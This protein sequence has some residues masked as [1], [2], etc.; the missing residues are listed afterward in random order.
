LSDAPASSD[1][2]SSDVP[3]SS[4]IEDVSSSIPIEPSSPIDSSLEQLIRYSYRLRQP[5]DY[6]SPSAFTSTA[7]S[8]PTSYR[9][10]VQQ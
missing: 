5:P 10:V 2:F 8:K 6:Y 9:D 1:E 3:P 4:F 7:L